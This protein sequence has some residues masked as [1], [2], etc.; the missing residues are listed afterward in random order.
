M[1]ESHAKEGLSANDCNLVPL[2]RMAGSI[3]LWRG[4]S[5]AFKAS[6]EGEGPADLPAWLDA[7]KNRP[8]NGF[9]LLSRPGWRA[10]KISS[11][12]QSQIGQRVEPASGYAPRRSRSAF[13]RTAQ[14]VL[15]GY[16]EIQLRAAKDAG[17]GTTAHLDGNHGSNGLS[18]SIPGR[19]NPHVVPASA[20]TK[21]YF[22]ISDVV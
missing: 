12:Q 19:G 9:L 20:N 2:L 7:P 22:E 5:N 13:E 21:T 8:G 4:S 15:A 14:P 6:I 17:K 16:W 18:G 3:A 1:R 10:A 11:Q